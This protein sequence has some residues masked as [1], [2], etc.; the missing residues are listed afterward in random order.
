M[1]KG[2]CSFGAHIFWVLL[3]GIILYIALRI[4]AATNPVAAAVFG[5][6]TRIGSLVIQ[7]VEYIAPKSISEL[8]L[9]SSEAYAALE[10]EYTTLKNTIVAEQ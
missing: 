10:K 2:L 5:V 3:I 6:F 9:V 1:A 8:E 7:L 4:F